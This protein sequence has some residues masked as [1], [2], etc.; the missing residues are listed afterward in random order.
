MYALEAAARYLPKLSRRGDTR[1]PESIDTILRGIPNTKFE[2]YNVKYD[3][4]IPTDHP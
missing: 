3:V 4:G 2:A 1:K